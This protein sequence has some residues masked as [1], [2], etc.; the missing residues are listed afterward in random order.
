MNKLLV[1]DANGSSWQ[2]LTTFRRQIWNF[3]LTLPSKI[4]PSRKDAPEKAPIRFENPYAYS[5]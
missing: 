2:I 1:K 4:E 5:R 3:T